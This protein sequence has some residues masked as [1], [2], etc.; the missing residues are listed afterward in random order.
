MDT[1]R[2]KAIESSE[3]IYL[4]AISE[5]ALYLREA[6]PKTNEFS[7]PLFSVEDLT[8]G[9]RVVLG[10]RECS[11]RLIP[12]NSVPTVLTLPQD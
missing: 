10:F 4:D 2:V 9:P 5:Q 8:D 6:L 1:N 7:I 3:D 11:S 12:C